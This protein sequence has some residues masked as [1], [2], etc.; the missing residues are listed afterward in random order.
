MQV[1]KTF[2]LVSLF[3]SSFPGMS[4]SEGLPGSSSHDTRNEMWDS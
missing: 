2:F 4:A 3:T 1:S